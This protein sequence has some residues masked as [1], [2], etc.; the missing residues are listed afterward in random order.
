MQLR[1]TFKRLITWVWHCMCVRL[2]LQINM[3]LNVVLV[4]KLYLRCE[5]IWSNCT[6][7]E[8]AES[9]VLHLCV[10]LGC[11]Y[12]YWVAPVSVCVYCE[13]SSRLPVRLVW[14]CLLTCL[15]TFVYSYSL[16]LGFN[17][18]YYIYNYISFSSVFIFTFTPMFS[19]IIYIHTHT[20]FLLLLSLSL[21]D[22]CNFI[23]THQ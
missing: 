6:I 18:L 10:I 15:Y 16:S 12:N 3:I 17:F 4:I 5:L 1:I 11:C 20:Y 9:S 2:I 14:I 22:A 19:Y 8:A 7:S 23:F 13:Y 21:N